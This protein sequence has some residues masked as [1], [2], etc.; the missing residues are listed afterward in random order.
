MADPIAAS[1]PP[2]RQTPPEAGAAAPP[3]PAPMQR[4]AML[5]FLLAGVLISAAYGANFL[6]ADAMT[7]A[8]RH[9]ADAGFALGLGSV[10]TVIGTLMAGRWAESRGVMP[11]LR[12]AALV[13]A[14]AMGCFALIAPGRPGFAMAAAC[15]GS[16]LLGLG[17]AVFFTLGPIQ[18]LRSLPP[19]RR[20]AVVTLISASQMIGLG[21]A[22]PLGRLAGLALPGLGWVHG[23]Y[24]LAAL[25]GWWL[26]RRSEA[27]MRGAARGPAPGLALTLAGALRVLRSPIAVPVAMTGLAAA[28]FA[29]LAVFQS[30]YA[31]SRGLPPELFFLGFTG[32]AILV[33]FVAVGFLARMPLDV[34]ALANFVLTFAGIALLLVNAGSLALYLAGTLLFAL[35]YGLTFSTLNAMQIQLAMARGLPVAIAS[36][37]FTLAYFLGLF[38][39]PALMGLVVRAGGIDAG[40]LALLAVVVIN[41]GISA[42]LCRHNR[43]PG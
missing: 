3:A 10:T 36:Q 40:L 38:G 28:V 25:L 21:L 15:A 6:L 26:L 23:L 14:A 39:F 27:A 9:A 8:G 30:P 19:E 13:L 18:M 17:W 24:G 5:P 2:A 7:A 1:V 35:G 22:T 12:A 37:V 16:V 41:L 42:G 43:R 31:E 33:R 32:I 4:T 29:G 34:T 20:I 11:L